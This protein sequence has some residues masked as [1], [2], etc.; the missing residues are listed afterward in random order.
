MGAM[1]AMGTHGEGTQARS[2]M[3]ASMPQC[4]G[5]PPLFIKTAENCCGRTRSYAVSAPQAFRRHERTNCSARVNERNV[6]SLLPLP[7]PCM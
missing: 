5:E 4:K 7:S 1:G 3:H 6:P 2:W